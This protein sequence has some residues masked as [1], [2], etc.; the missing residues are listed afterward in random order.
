MAKK[1]FEDMHIKDK[2]FDVIYHMAINDIWFDDPHRLLTHT[3]KD[4]KDNNWSL[5][6]NEASQLVYNAITALSE[7]KDV[8]TY[9][10]KCLF[11]AHYYEFAKYNGDISYEKKEDLEAEVLSKKELNIGDSIQ[12]YICYS[13]DECF[14]PGM[15]SVSDFLIEDIQVLSYLIEFWQSDG[16]LGEDY[17]NFSYCIRI[18][19]EDVDDFTVKVVKLVK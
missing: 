19:F 14:I 3:L 13:T 16:F 5:D 8:E 9:I 4:V 6:K 12:D 17:L 1:E 15:T 18:E 7:K 11:A 2:V 10:F